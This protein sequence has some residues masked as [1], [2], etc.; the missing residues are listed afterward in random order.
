M[1][2][3]WTLIERRTLFN[4]PRMKIIE[5]TVELPDGK[6]TEYLR[7]EPA[8]SHSVAVLAVN[9]DSQVLLQ[10]EYSYPPDEI[11]YQLPG[12]AAKIGEDIIEAANR[13]LSEESGY[14]GRDCQIIGSFYLNNRRSDRKQYVVL[15]RDLKMQKLQEDDEEFIE[16]AWMSLDNLKS[17]VRDGKIENVGLLAALSLFEWID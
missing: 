16:S 10:R 6:Q 1:I 11:L 5:D 13:E 17:L 14:I 15:C 2:S 7:E 8:I 4:H 12:G 9:D 3:K